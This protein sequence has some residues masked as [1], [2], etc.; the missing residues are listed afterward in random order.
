MNRALR[1]RRRLT[2]AGICVLSILCLAFYSD[3]RSATQSEDL[4]HRV[5][6]TQEILGTLAQAR[7]E[8]TPLENDSWGYRLTHDPKFEQQF[9]NDRRGLDDARKH[10]QQLTAENPSQ[11]D[12]LVELT[13]GISTYVTSLEESMQKA[14]LSYLQKLVDFQEFQETVSHFG[15]Y[16]FAVNHAAPPAAFIVKLPRRYS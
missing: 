1:F 2:V 6:H 7:L 12:L 14:A 8:R 5:A 13:A 11:Q 15:L 3:F 4:N 10:L 16:W 9:Q